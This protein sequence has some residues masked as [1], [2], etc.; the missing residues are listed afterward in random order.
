MVLGPTAS[1]KTELAEAVSDALQPQAPVRLISMDS[2][3]V[4]RGMDIG[5][6]KP[7][8]DEL[9][10]YP[11]ALIDIRDPSEPYSAADFVR[12][13]DA[14]VQQAH[15]A[16]EL[17]V[18]VGGTMLYAKAFRDGLA[19]LPKADPALRERLRQE[20][21]VQGWPALHAR[22]ATADPIAAAKIEPQNSQRLQRALEVLE[23]TGKPLSWW[24]HQPSQQ[25]AAA[26]LGVRLAQVAIIPSDR[27]LL[28]RRIEQRL[29]QML[30]QGLLAEVALLHQRGDL[31]LQL[32]SIRA[33]GYR[34]VWEH[35]DGAYG[36]DEMRQR[37]LAAT[38]QLAKRQ[39]TWLRGWP[40]LLALEPALTPLA[41]QANV[42]AV[43]RGAE[44]VGR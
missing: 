29:D 39:L 17:P 10:R 2:A 28:H 3:L 31:S 43:L 26:R 37:L 7:S 11:H 23:L 32:P 9:A 40:D 12:D 22:L 8:P 30:A 27:G 16:G 4:Y 14:Q 24:W 35:L 15:G 44:L 21:E 34:Q 25:S 36:L 5:T 42:A 18:L 1:G 38:R 41:L 13:A 20:A 33:V 19:D 6:A